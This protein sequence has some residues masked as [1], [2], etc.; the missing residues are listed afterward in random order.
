MSK[1]LKIIKLNR[2][3]LILLGV[4]AVIF[5]IVGIVTAVSGRSSGKV[6][7]FSG[8]GEYVEGIDVS[9][10]N[11][12]I[13]WE[14]V[15]EAVD[16]AIIRV[17]YRG[18]G[19]GA[20]GEDDKYAVNLETA[21]KVKIP[22][23]VYF[24][25]QAV[26]VEEAEEEAQLAIDL[27]K[28]YKI[29]LPVFIDFEFPL[30][31]NKTRIG[32]LSDA[33]LS[34]KEAAEIINTFCRKVKNA[35]YYAGVY[36]SSSILNFEIKTSDLDDDIYIWVADYN[37]RVTYFGKYDLW[38]YTKIGSCDGVNSKYTDRDRWYIKK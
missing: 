11:G 6:E 21:N 5:L 12:D 33:N 3:S 24:Y 2:K 38:Q 23:G 19:S 36:A 1:S 10:H 22:V 20:I 37:E 4:C 15:A 14:Q 17:G 8:S 16:F 28:P 26:T 7:F 31:S 34:G 29:T 13:D 35:G 30:D 25:S 27:I 18:Y 32:R 9:K